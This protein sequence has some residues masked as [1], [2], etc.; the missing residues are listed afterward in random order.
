[1]ALIVALVLVITLVAHLRAH[2]LAITVQVRA[3]LALVTI[4]P[5][6][7]AQA[8]VR[9]QV[10]IVLV[11]QV[12][13]LVQT[14]AIVQVLA[15]RAQVHIAVAHLLVVHPALQAV[16]EAVE[17]AAAVVEDNTNIKQT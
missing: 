11:P 14:Q 9:D 10:I 8:A 2:V 12:R 13:D 4:V 3:V 17:V 15:R 6:Q 7:V 1:M 5:D 16:V